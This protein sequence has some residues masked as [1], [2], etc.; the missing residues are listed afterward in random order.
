[1]RIELNNVCSSV[2][3]GK[4][5]IV[6]H[7][8]DCQDWTPYPKIFSLL[9]RP[10]DLPSLLH[11]GQCFHLH[12][13]WYF[14]H[15]WYTMNWIFF[16]WRRSSYLKY[17]HRPEVSKLWSTAQIWPTTYFC[18]RDELRTA[19]TF[20]N[21][22]KNKSKEEYFVTHKSYMKFKLVSINKDLL[23]HSH[24]LLFTYYLRLP[25]SY[26]SRAE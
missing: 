4:S 14:K 5:L 25:S 6:I 7:T 10:S 24:A 2:L 15:G 16:D 9:N 21:S 12:Q 20:L 3:Q 18:M 1:M 22:W 19:F 13:W 23:K 8:K 17:K 11:G 26:T